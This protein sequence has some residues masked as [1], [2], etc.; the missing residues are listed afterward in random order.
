MKGSGACGCGGGACSHAAT[1]LEQNLLELAF[2]RSLSGAASEG[3]AERVARL[4]D[5]GQVR[6]T[7]PPKPP[8]CTLVNSPIYMLLGVI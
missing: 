6:S 5:A 7:L 8:F 3:D 1:G 4:I 2:E